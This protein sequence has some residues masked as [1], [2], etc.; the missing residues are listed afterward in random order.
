MFAQLEVKEQNSLKVDWLSSIEMMS[1]SLILSIKSFVLLKGSSFVNN[2]H[3]FLNY[4]L[5]D[6]NLQ[7][8]LSVKDGF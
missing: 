2:S 3:R 8:D 4:L 7:L 1:A 6:C 5:F